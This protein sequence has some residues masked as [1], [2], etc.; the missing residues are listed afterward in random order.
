ME[1]SINRRVIDIHCFFSLFL[2]VHL[3]E[4]TLERNSVELFLQKKK[5]QQSL[6]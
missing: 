4:K 2:T 6:W 1:W 3:T 5:A